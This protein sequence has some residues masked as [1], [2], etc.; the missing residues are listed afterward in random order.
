MLASLNSNF[1]GNILMTKNQAISIFGSR[2]I[3]AECLGITQMAISYWGDELN[4]KQKDRVIGAAISN[5]YKVKEKFIDPLCELY[6]HFDDAEI[7][8]TNDG[9]ASGLDS[10]LSDIK[11]ESPYAAF[12]E[13]MLV[14][15]FRRTLRDKIQGSV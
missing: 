3:M 8:I 14:E 12:N 7:W 1:I 11:N 9:G 2:K 13:Y 15:L 4:K 6:M 10:Y 5:G